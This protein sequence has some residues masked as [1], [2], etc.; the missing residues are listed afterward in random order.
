MRGASAM[1]TSVEMPGVPPP[2][3]ALLIVRRGEPALFQLLRREVA[4]RP[5]V[6][7][8]LDRRVADR[9]QRDMGVAEDRRH[10]ERR[11][12]PSWEHDLR[13]R[14]YVLTRPWHRRPTD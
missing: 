2:V 10:H 9:R 3:R 5:E 7:V 11:S 1:L 6:A 4:G 8:L 12:L 13:V 14:K